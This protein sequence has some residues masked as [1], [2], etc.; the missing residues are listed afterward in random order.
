LKVYKYLKST[1]PYQS[2]KNISI[3]LSMPTGEVS[4]RHLVRDALRSGKGVFVPYLHK[5]PSA[6][7]GDPAFVMDMVSLHSEADYES[8]KPDRWGIPS[9]DPASMLKRA[10]CLGQRDTDVEHSMEAE[11]QV[12]LD[13]VLM[14]GVAFDRDHRRLG[15][16]KGYYDIFLARYQAQTRRLAQREDASVGVTTVASRDRMPYLGKTELAGLH[17]AN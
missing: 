14:P 5:D 9:I 6:G 1:E 10:R 8:L 12:K 17:T 13:M 15:H 16:G 3:Y 11:R 2:A 7:S 4:T